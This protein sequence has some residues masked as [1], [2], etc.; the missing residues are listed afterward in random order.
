MRTLRGRRRLC[1]VALIIWL[2][3]AADMSRAA[4]WSMEPSVALR[5]EYNDNFEF[6]SAPHSGVWGLLLAPDIKF[7]GET[8]ALKVTGGLGLSVN[9]YYGERGLDTTDHALTLRSSYKAERDVL[10]LSVDSIRDSTLVSELLETGVVEARRQRN[11]VTASPSWTRYL[12]E[13]TA[14]T[15]NYGYTDVRY[16]DTRG[17]SLIDY[18]DH[19]GTVGVLSNLSERDAVNVTAYYDLFLTDPK[20]F[21]A[22]TYGFQVKYDRAFSETLHGSLAVGARNTRSTISSQGVVCEGAILFGFCVGNLTTFTAVNTERSTGYTFLASVDKKLE[23]ALLTARLS[24]ELNPTGVGALVQTDRLGITWTQQWSPTV[25]AFVDASIYQSRYVSNI[26]A[27]S[28]SRYYR[29]EPRVTWRIT[30]AWTLLGGYS[31]SHVQ[32]EN[33][34]AAASANVIYAVVSYTWPKLSVSR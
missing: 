19:T 18:R 21:Q 11:Q 33:S 23:T 25:S 34:S 2:G 30:E 32:Y 16:A 20:T 24:R 15:A 12:T 27:S 31:Y 5:T 6:T 8:E 7:S 14:L 10:G 29:I 26:I 22:K 9:R 4:E 17:T 13:S 28:N 1:I 3:V